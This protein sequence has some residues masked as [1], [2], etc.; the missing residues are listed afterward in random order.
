M[1]EAVREKEEAVGKLRRAA[2]KLMD[3][4][5]KTSEVGDED[6]GRISD[7]EKRIMVLTSWG[8]VCFES[9]EQRK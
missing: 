8:W 6:E 9:A 5:G 3:V 4:K 2:S 1:D 7:L